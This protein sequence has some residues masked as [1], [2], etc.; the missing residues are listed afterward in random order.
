VSTEAFSIHKPRGFSKRCCPY[1]GSREV[2]RLHR[3]VL[4][5]ATSASVMLSS[6]LAPGQ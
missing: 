5:G 4:R 2:W 1:C 6:E 3:R